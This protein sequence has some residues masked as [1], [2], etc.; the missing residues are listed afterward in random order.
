M[1]KMARG[2]T[3]LC[4]ALALRLG[5]MARGGGRTLRSLLYSDTWKV[6]PRTTTLE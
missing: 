3:G 6:P 4:Q 5:R 2:L 1:D